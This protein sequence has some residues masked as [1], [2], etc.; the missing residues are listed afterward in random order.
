WGVISILSNKPEDKNVGIA[1]FPLGDSNS[2][3]TVAGNAWAL[4]AELEGAKKEA[5]H[6]F[7]KWMFSEEFY[8]ELISVGRIV[9]ANVEMPEDTDHDP[10]FLEMVRLFRESTP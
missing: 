2:V 8:K 10:L 9:A 5:A 7:M 4:N 1:I 6:T 3:S